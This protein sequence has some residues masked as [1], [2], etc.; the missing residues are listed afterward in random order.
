MADDNHTLTRLYADAYFDLENWSQQLRDSGHSPPTNLLLEGNFARTVLDAAGRL[1]RAGDMLQC[2]KRQKSH[3][4]AARFYY[5]ASLVQLTAWANAE[6]GVQHAA[7][8]QQ[9]P[10]IARPR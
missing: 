3:W 10:A 6:G 7:P 4:T 1:W 8:L 5:N 9:R 2:L